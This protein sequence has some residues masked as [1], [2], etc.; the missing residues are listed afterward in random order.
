MCVTSATVFGFRS[1]SGRRDGELESYFKSLSGRRVGKLE[2]CF[3]SLYSSRDE[4]VG[5]C[6]RS[7]SGRWGEKRDLLVPVFCFRSLAVRVPGRQA[8]WGSAEGHSPAVQPQDNKALTKSGPWSATRHSATCANVTSRRCACSITSSSG[9]LVVKAR[10]CVMFW[11]SWRSSSPWYGMM[12][13][14]VWNDFVFRVSH[15]SVHRPGTEMQRNSSALF[16]FCF[17]FAHNY[18]HASSMRLKNSNYT[19]PHSYGASCPMPRF[20]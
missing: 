6:F 13:E 8:A 12:T 5:L 3:K 18:I 7:L 14:G 19:L 1:L 20:C 2:S 10:S 15:R 11:A 9:V 4:E 17:L 16:L